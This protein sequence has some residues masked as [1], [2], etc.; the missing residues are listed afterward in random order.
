MKLN[1]FI[2]LFFYMVFSYAYADDD[3][4]SKDLDSVKNQIKTIDKEIKENKAKKAD[5]SKELKV[6]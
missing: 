5:I 3:E 2:F 6:Q 1:H 4:S